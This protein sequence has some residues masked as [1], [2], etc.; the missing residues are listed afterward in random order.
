M[1]LTVG[2][3]ALDLTL[4]LVLLALTAPLWAVVALVLAAGGRGRVLFTQVR[5]G[6]DGQPFTILK[7]RTMTDARDEHGR[8]LPDELRLTA[9]GRVMRRTSLDELPQLL[10]VLRGD[11]SLVGPRPLLMEYL[12]LYTREQA[13]R[14]GVRPG[15]T[16]LAQVEGRNGISWE[17]RFALDVH[18]VDN[19]SMGLD[20]D[21]L[22]RTLRRV[23]SGE[24]VTSG[25]AATVERFR[26]SA[27][28]A[29]RQ[30][31]EEV[32]R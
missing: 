26:G 19:V 15:I 10:N 20:I 4:A 32:R 23:L 14:H 24:G 27:A 17:E 5:P 2:K 7:F 11:L 1:Y 30:A 31:F 12:P 28:T 18:Y 16:G 13:R 22:R 21:I 6:L 25:S 8:L 3:R 29:P 9:L